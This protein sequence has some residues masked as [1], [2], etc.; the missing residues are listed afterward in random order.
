MEHDSTH[1]SYLKAEYENAP[2][3]LPVGT[4]LELIGLTSAVFDAVYNFNSSLRQA[5]HPQKS[6]DSSQERRLSVDHPRPPTDVHIEDAESSNRN[7]QN[8]ATNQTQRRGG[9]AAPESIE[10]SLSSYTSARYTT[11]PGSPGLR[12]HQLSYGSPFQ[13]IFEGDTSAISTIVDLYQSVA[14]IVTPY[15]IDARETAANLTNNILAA[16][17]LERMN[18][19]W[20]FLSSQDKDP[21]DYWLDPGY[22][23]KPSPLPP[24]G[25]SKAAICDI[26]DRVPE[27]DLRNAGPVATSISISLSIK[28]SGISFKLIKTAEH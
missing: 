8:P 12:V 7:P 10:G 19:R 15:L 21:S 3:S 24:A 16:I 9:R 13:G 27:S 26:A 20:G 5:Q 2:R 4:T 18:S 17:I 1:T 25:G 22:N 14:P 28:F 23:S 6:V 11:R